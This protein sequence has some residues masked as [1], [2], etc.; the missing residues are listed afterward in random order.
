MQ[1]E[2]H[3]NF[4]IM[5]AVS[6]P[7]PGGSGS[8]SP[9]TALGEPPTHPAASNADEIFARVQAHLH[10]EI[11]GGRR[12]RS[13][14]RRRAGSEQR[15]RTWTQEWS[16]ANPDAQEGTSGSMRFA[17]RP[18]N[19]V[20]LSVQSANYASSSSN[21]GHGV[22]FPSVE[23]PRDTRAAPLPPMLL[24]MPPQKAGSIVPPQGYDF[25]EGMSGKAQR[26]LF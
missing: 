21:G 20:R 9:V 17:P 26:E 13:S 22:T 12:P 24:P 19:E 2:S 18:K 6:S 1:G 15:G 25:T 11:V 16:S 5:P 7:V 10:A 14:P 23:S 4:T 8:G 3:D